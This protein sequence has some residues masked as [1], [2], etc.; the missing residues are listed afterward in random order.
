MLGKGELKNM[1]NKKLEGVKVA[2]LVTDGFEQV[3]PTEPKHALDEAGT[4]TQ[5]VSP[6]DEHTR[7][8][9]RRRPHGRLHQFQR[10]FVRRRVK[11]KSYEDSHTAIW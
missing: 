10:R 4:K 7:R 1:A 2:I 9:A 8:I 5:S 11:Q 6:Q 3:E